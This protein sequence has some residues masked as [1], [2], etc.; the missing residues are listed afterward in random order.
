MTDMARNMPPEAM[1]VS[2]GETVLGRI[3]TA[4]ECADL[5]AFLLDSADWTPAPASPPLRRRPDHFLQRP[6]HLPQ[7]FQDGLV[8][9]HQMVQGVF[10]GADGLF[11]TRK[12][13]FLPGQNRTVIRTAEG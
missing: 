13:F 5:V 11:Q 6:N 9:R 12:V 2:L 10:L 7:P 4:E 3:A 8:L 1:A